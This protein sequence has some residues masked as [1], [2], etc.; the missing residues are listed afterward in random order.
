MKSDADVELDIKSNKVKEGYLVKRSRILKELKTRWMVLT[1][2][3][4][5]SFT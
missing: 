1:K 5:Y 2:T 3:H 4:L